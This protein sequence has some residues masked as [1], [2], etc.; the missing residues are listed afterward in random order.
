N[1]FI[2]LTTILIPSTAITSTFLPCSI[3][4]PSETTSTLSSPIS[5]IPAGLKGVTVIPSLPKNSG[6]T[7]VVT[8]PCSVIVRSFKIIRLKKPLSESA[9][10]YIIIIA[11]ISTIISIKIH[12]AISPKSKPDKNKETTTAPTPIIP[13]THNSTTS[14][15]LATDCK[16]GTTTGF[17]TNLA[18]SSATVVSVSSIVAS[19]KSNSANNSSRFFTTPSA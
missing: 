3:Y 5:A 9:R 7:S 19:V 15:K 2:S 11:A 10:R 13:N 16:I 14:P 18:N 1:Y 6:L 12:R 4:V 8:Y 17:V